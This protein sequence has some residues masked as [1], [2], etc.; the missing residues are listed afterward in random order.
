LRP[1]LGNP[2]PP[3]FWGSTKKL[4][5]GFDTKLGEI[6]ATGFEAKSEK[7]IAT[8]FEAKPEKTVATG[9][10]AKPKKIDATGFEAKPEKTVYHR[11]WCQTTGKPSTLVLR[12]N[13]ET[14]APRL[15]VHG[16]ADCT[17]RH[18]TSWSSGYRV[19]DLCDHPRSSAPILLLLPC[20]SSLLA[21]P[22]LPSVHHEASK[23]DSPNEAKI[24]VKPP[25]MS[26][27]QIQTSSSQWLK[28]IKPKNWA[29]G[30]SISPLMSPLTTQKH[31]VWI[32]NPRP[33]EAQ[34][35]D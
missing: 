9:F 14:C 19:P 22:H 29:L 2:P 23:R 1:K 26:Q 16:G 5:T 12:L 21:M 31:K 10:E 34:L 3:G 25:K 15:L 27:I 6:V 7:T 13:Q 4:T 11:F 24:M 30:F 20:S 18:Q 33:N 8:D 17:Q 28:I 35:E 32:L